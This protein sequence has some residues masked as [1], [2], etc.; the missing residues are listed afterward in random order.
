M[1]DEIPREFSVMDSH[2]H[3]LLRLDPEVAQGWSGTGRLVGRFFAGSSDRLK[4]AANSQFGSVSSSTRVAAAGPSRECN[5]CTS[6][7]VVFLSFP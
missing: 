6:I 7:F 1:K 4:E 5:A 2:L 3:L